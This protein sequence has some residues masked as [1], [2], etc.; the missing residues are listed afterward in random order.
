MQIS[1]GR[2]DYSVVKVLAGHSFGE[3]LVL[4]YISPLAF[5]SVYYELLSL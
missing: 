5:V 3:T 4:L 2:M 1:S